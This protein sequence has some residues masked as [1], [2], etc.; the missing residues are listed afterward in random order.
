MSAHATLKQYWGYDHFRPLQ[1]EIIDSV[2]TGHDTLALL[3]TGGG[4]SIC[5]QVPA[6]L[7]EGICIVVSPLIALM[8][9]Q[10]E[11]LKRRQIAATAIY[12]GM[13]KREIDFGLDNCVYGQYKFLYVSPE[14]L[15][16]ELL[17]ARVAKMNVSLLAI[18]EAH[19]I[20]Q[21]G[22]DFRP[23]YREIAEFRQVIPEVTV[24]ALTATATAQ[25]KQDIQEQLSFKK[26]QV[27]QQSFARAN[28]SY[29]V[30]YEEDK[31]Q[32]LL[33]ILRNVPG[34]SVVYVRSRRRTESVVRQLR[35]HQILA[36][37]YHAGL[38]PEQR[39][40]RQDAWIQDRT[41]VIV[42]TNAFGMGIDK[43]NVR[44]VVH[45][46]LPDSIE[47]YYQEAGRAGRDEQKAYAVVLYDQNDTDRLI[48]NIERSFPPLPTLRTVYQNLANYLRIA[49]GSSMLASY[50]FNLEAFVKT[51]QMSSSEAY[52]SIKRLE[53]TG[54]LQLSESFYA[55]SRLHVSLDYQSLYKYRI[56]NAAFEPLLDL[57]LRLYGGELYSQ[58]VSISE[59]QLAS[60]LSTSVSDVTK[61]LSTLHQ[62]Q[63]VMY[64]PRRDQPQL[65]FVT[66]RFDANKLPL[67]TTDL[68]QRKQ[69]HLRQ[70]EAVVKYVKHPHRC[71]TQLL[72]AYFGEDFRAECGVC[73]HCLR[74]ARERHGV[75][76]FS[77]EKHTETSTLVTSNL[78]ENPLTV[79]RLAS[80][81]AQVDE[82]LLLHTIKLM[83]DNGK[84]YYDQQGRLAVKVKRSKG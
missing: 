42:S 37:F 83:L 53:E 51:Y 31:E 74:R 59:S 33:K 40:Q 80:S 70:A 75:A 39:S 15:K 12:S 9:D 68:E 3:P 34:T 71:R 38:E 10:V 79:D 11:Q 36:D 52:Y 23:A 47:A 30:L 6:M 22:H 65:L 18:D 32:R 17:L 25:V 58:Y 8:K 64:S 69:A 19:C 4:K 5:F 43:P 60:Q 26:G 84:L 45:L 67:K 72:L 66:P 35:A 49:V 24:I 21:W 57:V 2:L 1:E 73:D 16:T 81:L 46:D 41:R 20:S 48:Q 50:D 62:Q 78:H 56:A 82:D 13:S 29:S 55:P 28:L 61:M 7:R 14:R 44:T 54:F 63:V 27:F 77:E 76:G